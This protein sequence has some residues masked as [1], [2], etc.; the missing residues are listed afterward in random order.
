MY[1]A[2]YTTGIHPSADDKNGHN[3]K[4]ISE[5]RRIQLSLDGERFLMKFCANTFFLDVVFNTDTC[6]HEEKHD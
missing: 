5:G 6:S 3:Q 4:H 2:R 1:P